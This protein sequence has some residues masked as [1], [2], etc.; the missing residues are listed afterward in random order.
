MES[1]FGK[2][3]LRQSVVILYGRFDTILILPQFGYLGRK[4]NKI[5][6]DRELDNGITFAEYQLPK[7]QS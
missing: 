5:R 6:S 2:Y 3:N 7:P 4:P 1:P